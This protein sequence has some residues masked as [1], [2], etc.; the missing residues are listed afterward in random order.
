MQRK[1]QPWTMLVLICLIA[2]VLSYSST[3]QQPTPQVC[4]PPVPPRPPAHLSAP[5]SLVP[6]SAAD[7]NL[8]PL[9]AVLLVGPIDGN[10]GSW[11][12]QE[13]ANMELAAAELESHAVTVYRFYPGDSDRDEIEQA[14]NGAHFLLYRG[15]GVYDGNLP[16]PNVGGFSLSSGYYSSDTI[17]QN[18]HLATNSIVMLY[19]CFT[20]GSSSAPGDEHDIGIAEASRRVAQYS[21][22][23]FDVG[24]AGY[25]ANWFGNAFQQFL[26]NLFAGQTLG[27]AYENYSDFNSNTV[28]RTTHPDHPGMAMWVDKDNWGYWQ[29][30]N[31]FAGKPNETLEDLFS[32]PE[33]TGIPTSLTFTATVES[34]V[35]L[36]PAYYNVTPG[37]SRNDDDLDWTV[38][39]E[40]NWF[41]VSPQTGSTPNTFTVTPQTFDTSRP[42]TYTGAVTV[43]VTSPINTLN[44]VQR[45]NLTLQVFAPQLGGLP[46][47]VGFVYSSAEA[48]F[49]SDEYRITPE[50]VGS[51][52]SLQWQATTDCDW[53][54]ITPTGGTTPQNFTLTA[55]DFPTTTV[56]T[57]AGL[58]TVTV[59]SPAQTYLSP[60]VVPVTLKVIDTPFARAYLSLI[61]RNST[62][63]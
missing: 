61:F 13:I 11:T 51:D 8:P 16:H 57:Y 23:F 63:P 20:A 7:L 25:Y 19:G 38:D 1:Y 6:R 43:T 27:Q 36:E 49:L 24:A 42:G 31:A 53:L 60:Q 41:S 35:H 40:G 26:S 22:P 9:K 4:T 32:L 17:R 47:L 30:N 37:N 3:A 44:P 21:D 29:Y 28:Y 56:A 50:N 2:L 12:R 33:L 39:T 52:A 62:Y 59:T 10:D 15:H 34:G 55:T 45:I 18:L 46:S 58:L 54:T 14:A 5:S 48:G